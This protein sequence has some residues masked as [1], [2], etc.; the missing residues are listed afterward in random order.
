MADRLRFLLKRKW[1]SLSPHCFVLQENAPLFVC[2]KALSHHNSVF[3]L[4]FH[5]GF[6][7][8][9]SLTEFNSVPQLIE[10]YHRN[11]SVWPTELVRNSSIKCSHL[12][13]LNSPPLSDTYDVNDTNRRESENNS[14]SGAGPV[15][16]PLGT[17]VPLRL[18]WFL[19]V[20]TRQYPSANGFSPQG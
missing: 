2:I 19:R 3:W 8:T 15:E 5:R 6:I 11:S 20:V 4:F 13:P 18:G 9:N 14:T 1:H 12:P 10:D 17:Q 7:P 16:L